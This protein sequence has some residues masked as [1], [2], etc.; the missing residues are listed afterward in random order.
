MSI[1]R[2][3]IVFLGLVVALSCGAS[4]AAP[5]MQLPVGHRCAEDQK[6]DIYCSRYAGGDGV[7]DRTTGEVMCGKGHCQPDYF[8]K[9]AIVCAKT[10]D[11]VAAYN[12]KGEVVCSGGCERATK[13]MCEKLSP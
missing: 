11:G 13:E 1:P 10:T 2:R 6:G 9:G 12:A 8:K 7:E 4:L 3:S 5:E